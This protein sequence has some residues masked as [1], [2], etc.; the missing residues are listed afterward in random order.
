M[1][2]TLALEALSV[3][4]VPDDEKSCFILH[5]LSSTPIPNLTVN[6]SYAELTRILSENKVIVCTSRVKFLNWCAWT[7]VALFQGLLHNVGHCA[8]VIGE[9]GT[10]KSFLFKKIAAS[11][12]QLVPNLLVCYIQYKAI[13][14]LTPLQW[15]VRLMK[16]K[17]N[18]DWSSIE[19]MDD[20]YKQLH[21]RN[22]YLIFYVD[23]LD[24]V[25]AG[26][27]NEHTAIITQLLAISEMSYSPRRIVV[28]AT[29]SSVCLRRLCFASATEDDIKRF[30]SYHGKSFN[31]RKYI[32]QTVGSLLSVSELVNAKKVLS[33]SRS[34]FCDGGDDDVGDID[35]AHLMSELSLTRGVMQCVADLETPSFLGTQRRQL[36]TFTEKRNDV[37]LQKLWRALLEVLR[38]KSPSQLDAV[39]SNADLW[40]ELPTVYFADMQ[41]LDSSIEPRDLYEWSDKGFLHIADIHAETSQCAHHNV[42]FAHGTDLMWAVAALLSTKVRISFGKY[43]QGT[44]NSQEGACLMNPAGTDLHEQL[45]AESLASSYEYHIPGVDVPLRF[46]YE[47]Q[48][49][50]PSELIS[51]VKWNGELYKLAPDTGVDLVALHDVVI[52]DVPTLVVLLF[53]C[54][55][56]QRADGRLS[57]NVSGK[58]PNVEDI[59]AGIQ[60]NVENIRP[61]FTAERLA[62]RQ[63]RFEKFLVTPL[64]ASDA[65]RASLV[66]KEIRHIDRHQLSKLWSPRVKQFIREG[67]ETTAK[68]RFLLEQS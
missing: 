55:M 21:R 36:I 25:F 63:L 16:D 65:V 24:T 5:S 58:H 1:D 30:P 33:L 18:V 20:L 51:R 14:S 62:G 61:L 15:L 48:T 47:Y 6:N 40:A 53:Q 66:V 27:G 60:R 67:G 49:L 68:L 54:K 46:E 39:I 31:D 19:S 2:F 38:E 3:A 23:E 42:G 8:I 45:I 37:H 59:S 52:Q 35:D 64:L 17:H 26:H 44:L 56:T 7:I 41:S 4:D 9:R 11:S 28:V 34:N 10:G 22:Q 50:A 13:D 57:S 29:G 12:V 32:L 43:Q